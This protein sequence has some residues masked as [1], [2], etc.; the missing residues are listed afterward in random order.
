LNIQ[1]SGTKARRRVD[2]VILLSDIPAERYQSKA[3]CRALD[4]LESFA[5]DQARYG[6]KELAARIHMPMSSLFRVLATLETRG[7]IAQL[8]NG[9]YRL[10]PRVVHGKL[11]EQADRLTELAHPFLH[12][13]AGRFNETASLALL[14]ENRIQVLDSVNAFHAVRVINTPGRVLPPHCSSLGKAITAF[15]PQPLLD[16]ILEVQGLYPRTAHSL[17]DRGA[18]LAE[19]GRVRESGYAAD[20]EEAS[21]GG[22]CFGVP[23]RSADG[24]VRAAVSVSSV[25]SRMTAERERDIIQELLKTARELSAVV[26]EANAR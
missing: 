18:V 14:F 8:G 23:I 11:R 24:R 6:L 21:E 12:Q 1:K 22:I 17:R 15:Q 26:E 3:I 20:R 13:L 2:P 19:L 9:S 10:T 7:Y 25:A 4:V 16:Q 5:D